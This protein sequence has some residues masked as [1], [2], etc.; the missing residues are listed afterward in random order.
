MIITRG[1]RGCDVIYNDKFLKKTIEEPTREVDESGA[2][3]AFIS[4]FIRT[5]IEEKKIDDK[6]IS[7]SIIRALTNSSKCVKSLG[8]RGH[9]IKPYKVTSYE[10][11]I[12]RSIDVK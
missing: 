5:Y 6:M 1:K 3:D 11:C 4:E 2:G 12:C 7:K 10:K 8:A 9:I